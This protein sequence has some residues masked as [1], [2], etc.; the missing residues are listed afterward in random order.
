MLYLQGSCKCTRLEN[1]SFGVPILVLKIQ[2]SEKVFVCKFLF[3][4]PLFALV[5]RVQ[6][7]DRRVLLFLKVIIQHELF[8]VELDKEESLPVI[9]NQSKM[10]WVDCFFRKFKQVPFAAVFHS[11]SV[12]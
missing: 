6:I 5:E 1:W 7:E 4:I 11:V 3:C 9:T 2:A 12:D 10:A 8:G